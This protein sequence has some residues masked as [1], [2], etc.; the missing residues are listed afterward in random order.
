MSINKDDICGK[1][2]KKEI[3]EKIQEKIKNNERLDPD[4][5]NIPISHFRI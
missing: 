3:R 4:V 1:K 5:Y 2:Y